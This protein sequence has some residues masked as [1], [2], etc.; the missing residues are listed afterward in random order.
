MKDPCLTR[1]SNILFYMALIT[2][3]L[4]LYG[5][6]SMIWVDSPIVLAKGT[7]IWQSTFHKIPKPDLWLMIG[8]ITLPMAAWIYGITQIML[9]A[10][11]YRV[12]KIFGADNSKFFVRL[13]LAMMV[14]GLFDSLTYPAINY[15]LYYRHISPWLG[16][17]DIFTFAKPDLLMAGIFFLVIGKI[18]QR[19]AELEETDQLTV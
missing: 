19:G 1:W 18:M 3:L 7:E 12:G 14:M 9:L 15:L 5:P 4:S 13:G 11:N 17:M 16:D 6:L 2:A 10:K 8:I